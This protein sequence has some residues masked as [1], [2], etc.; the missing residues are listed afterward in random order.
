M[1]GGDSL[2]DKY[3]YVITIYSFFDM[4]LTLAFI[5]LILLFWAGT[6]S[7]EYLIGKNINIIF[8]VLTGIVTIILRIIRMRLKYKR[9]R[10][11]V[12]NDEFDNK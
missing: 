4:L 7:G 2:K 1:F 3:I 10:F 12:E 5:I 9:F 6:L 8:L 11:L